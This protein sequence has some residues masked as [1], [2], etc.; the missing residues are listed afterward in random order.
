MLK[1]HRS[2]AR[3]PARPSPE[4][5]QRL[6]DGRIAGAVAALKMTD[7][8]MKLWAPVEA[9]IR[10]GQAARL[11]GMQARMEQRKSGTARPDLPDR[12]DRMSAGLAER[13]ERS[14]A[15]A[16]A[17][18]PFHASLNDAQKSVIGPVLAQLQG[19][20]RGRHQR[21]AMHGRAGGAP[22]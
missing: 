4:T 21:W 19:G 18:K 16:A 5:I 17:F 8:Q 7:T 2:P 13:A 11:K 15:F 14:K 12:L 9:Q 10:A 6:Q 22:Q 3:Q 20:G 1:P